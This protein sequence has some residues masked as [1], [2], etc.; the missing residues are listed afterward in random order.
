MN[1]VVVWLFAQQVF[2]KATPLLLAALGGLY[3]ERTGVINIA[4]EGIMLVGAL[5]AVL[6][7]YFTGVPWAGVG[8]AA[9]CGGLMGIV[10]ALACVRLKANVHPKE[11]TLIDE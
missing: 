4:L 6:G 3:C 5:S 8:I 1:D 9:L 7:A 2:A 10:M 11:N